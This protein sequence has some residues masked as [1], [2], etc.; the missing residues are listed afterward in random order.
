MMKA[1]DFGRFMGAA[2]IRHTCSPAEY[3]ATLT[4]AASGIVVHVDCVRCRALMAWGAY[5]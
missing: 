2:G 5:T 4:R 3:D 1:I